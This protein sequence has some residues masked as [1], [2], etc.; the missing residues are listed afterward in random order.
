MAFWGRLDS[1]HGECEAIAVMRANLFEVFLSLMPLPGSLTQ[2][3]SVP[4]ITTA[5]WPSTPSRE[6]TLRTVALSSCPL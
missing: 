1:Q 5:V 3:T 2:T 6:V 4:S